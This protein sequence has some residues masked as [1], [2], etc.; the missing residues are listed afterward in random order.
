MGKG[1]IPKSN[2]RE[3]AGA[4]SGATPIGPGDEAVRLRAKK[5]RGSFRRVEA[6]PNIPDTP[7]P[8]R[9]SP[10]KGK[11]VSRILG[12]SNT[13]AEAN[14]RAGKLLGTEPKTL[15]EAMPF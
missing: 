15:P 6:D 9:S 12:T 13:P 1:T 5:R 14:A 7:K 11:G 4:G 3:R 10:R 8:Q 2:T